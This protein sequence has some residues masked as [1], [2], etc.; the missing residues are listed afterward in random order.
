MALDLLPYLIASGAAN[1][2]NTTLTVTAGDNGGYP[3]LPGDVVIVSGGSGG[4]QPTGV[5]DSQGHAYTKI[6]GTNTSPANSQWVATATHGLKAPGPGITPDTITITYAATS[7]AKQWVVIGCQYLGATDSAMS[8]TPAS[9]SST[10]PSA[11]SNVP[12]VSGELVAAL[13]VFSNAGGT[14]T[15]AAGW[16]LVATITLGSNAFASLAVRIGGAASATAAATLATSTTWTMTIVGVRPAA[17]SLRAAVGGSVWQAAYPGLGYNDYQAKS[18]FDGF[19]GRTMANRACKRYLSEGQ[20]ESQANQAQSV[21]TYTNT[22][23]IFCVVSVK[24]TRAVGGGVAGDIP[25]LSAMLTYWK[26]NGV[27]PHVILFNESNINGANGHFGTG[28]AFTPPETTPYGSTVSAA[29]AAA[30]YQDYFNYYGPTVISAGLQCQYNPAI[31]S[32]TP[33]GTFLPARFVLGSATTGWCTG[34]SIDIYMNDTSATY[35]SAIDTTHTLDALLALCDAMTPTMPVGIGEM[36]FTDG[37]P[38]P[39]NTNPSGVAS[40]LDTEITGKLAPRQ[41][42]GKQN[43]PVLWYANG[44]GNT[45]NGS[46]DAGIIAAVQRMYDGLSPSGVTGGFPSVT[47]T[48]LPLGEVG[49]A[50]STTMAATGSGP[51]TWSKTGTS[52]PGLS[53][54]SAGAWSGTPT[55]AGTYAF[56]VTCTDAN[57]AQTTV[58]VTLVINPSLTVLTTTAVLPHFVAGVP[59]VFGLQ[60]GGGVPPVTWA[61]I[62]GAL[63]SGVTLDPSGTGSGTDA[64]AGTA[65]FTVRATDSAGVTATAALVLTTDAAAAAGGDVSGDSLILAGRFQLLG[66][67]VSDDPAC[68]GA[69]FMLGRPG[70]DSSYDLGMP[71]PVI[72]VLASLGLDG[73]R[74]MGRRAA[75]RVMTLPLVIMAPDR[76]TLAAAREALLF[77]IDADS[78]EV[79]WTRDGGMPLVFDCFRA[80]ATTYHY[81]LVR[82]NQ[83]VSIMD[84]TFM[85]LPYGRS[86]DLETLAF[87]PP[88]AG[89]PPPAAPVTVDDYTTVGSSSGPGQWSQETMGVSGGSFSAHWSRQQNAC[90]DYVRTLTS[91]VNL[92]GRTRLSFW[93]GLA[94]TSDQYSVWHRGPVQFDIT[95]TDTAGETARMAATVL[96]HASGK[97]GVPEWTKISVVV[98]GDT[99]LDTTSIAAYQIKAWNTSATTRASATASRARVLQAD[100]YLSWLTTSPA[101]VGVPGL[102]GAAYDL[103]GILGSA[104]SPLAVQVQ[105]GPGAAAQVFTRATAGT[106]NFTVPAG[107][108]LIYPE[109]WGS[110]GGGGSGSAG[111]VNNGGAGGGGG[112]YAAAPGWQVSPGQVVAVTVGAAGAQSIDPAGAGGG[113]GGSGGDTFFTIGG[114]E[115]LRAH[116]GGGGPRGGATNSTGGAGGTGS[117][118]PVHYDGGDGGPPQGKFTNPHTPGSGGGGSGG[119]SQQGNDGLPTRKIGDDYGPGIGAAAVPGGGPGAKGG[120][121]T[122]GTVPGVGPG[123]GGGGGSGASSGTHSGAGHAGQA[124]ISYGVPVVAPLQTL[125]LHRPGHSAPPAYQPLVAVGGGADPPN[126]SIEYPVAS[127][128]P[129]VPAKFGGRT[130]TVIACALSWHGTAARTVTV[131][132]IQYDGI[133]QPGDLP[134]GGGRTTPVSVTR[135]ISPSQAPN[136]I[137]VIDDVPLPPR[138]LAD[139]QAGVSYTV[140]IASTDTADRFL[141][142]LILD[143][144]GSTVLLD[145]S[146]AGFNNVWLDAPEPG[147][148]IGQLLGSAGDRDSASSI[149]DDAKIT[150]PPMYADPGDQ[151]L[152]AYSPDGAP[153]LFASYLPRWFID[154]LR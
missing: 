89:W 77:A 136:G 14:I 69:V 109:G 138:G 57:S 115:I 62:A 124:V 71:Q 20:Y 99:L 146:S 68:E 143:S 132:I 16:K 44:T 36:G 8:P 78:F 19:V 103:R 112:E 101:V 74:P 114:A 28:S 42:A 151:W 72:D 4:A 18:A 59:G 31:S 98:P 116:G 6:T 127:Q 131:T 9:G 149:L 134:D 35:P 26:N 88:S 50:Y 150:G 125:V 126:G 67:E 142:V 37:P 148:G 94:T 86:T 10:A 102:R 119:Q 52:P 153:A 154:R 105:P 60:Y 100:A 48:S 22:H 91:V 130:H 41:A 129:G 2:G 97:P 95:L 73:E 58:T 80:G 5:T 79:Q 13:C 141:D 66:Q 96:C 1:T 15:W 55:T 113:P 111:A 46:T 64:D 135:T 30:N 3:A 24:P 147:M 33:A 92:G 87:P 21:V 11:T 121:S 17:Q 53:M 51:F 27:A 7:Q 65:A 137:F 140:T 45:I 83:L 104:R 81:S 75:N 110:G 70:G 12:A 39:Q 106:Q 145:T 107:T 32:A 108:T 123:G 82:D 152:L 122:A 118:S 49:R 38:R 34:C 56:P 40:W 25:L 23:G 54:S 29:Q 93:L 128:V 76:G 120:D 144:E 47:T 139:D 117:Q 61:V 43:L 133:S 85:A 90:P 84:I 63:P